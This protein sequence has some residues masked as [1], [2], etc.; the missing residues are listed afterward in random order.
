M[1]HISNKIENNWARTTHIVLLFIQR[2]VFKSYQR[3]YHEC[4]NPHDDLVDLFAP[5][6]MILK[7]NQEGNLFE[8]ERQ[9]RKAITSI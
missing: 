5:C 7:M 8:T 1:D 6:C 2:D 4:K 9:S 3:Q